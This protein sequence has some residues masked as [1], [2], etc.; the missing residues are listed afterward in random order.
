M[1]ALLTGSV[2]LL[3]GAR[4]LRTT[5]LLRI[6]GRLTMSKEPASM[7]KGPEAAGAVWNYPPTLR[8]FRSG[9]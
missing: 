1:E 9:V 2:Y 5:G 6:V 4:K 7:Y 8:T 3:A